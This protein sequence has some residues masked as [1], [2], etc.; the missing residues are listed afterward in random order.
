MHQVFDLK[1]EGPT[2]KAPVC[3]KSAIWRAGSLQLETAT[4][5]QGLVRSAP[6]SVRFH[7]LMSLECLCLCCTA[8][9]AEVATAIAGRR[10]IDMINFYFV[11]KVLQQYEYA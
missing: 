5:T 2:K 10:A 4:A 3:E 6:S 8:R 9:R 11:K 1:T 7:V